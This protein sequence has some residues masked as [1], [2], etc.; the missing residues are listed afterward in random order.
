MIIEKLEALG[1]ASAGNLIALLTPSTDDE[2]EGGANALGDLVAAQQWISINI[3]LS[4]RVAALA[5][6]EAFN[7]ALAGELES[8]DRE[9]AAISAG[10]DAE[11]A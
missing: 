3:E 6:A 10:L 7:H 5:V 8:L 11:A 2:I 4:D 1:L 9:I